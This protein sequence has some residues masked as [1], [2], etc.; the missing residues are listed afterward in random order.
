MEACHDALFSDLFDS[1]K[2]AFL[3]QGSLATLDIKM[4]LRSSP[5]LYSIAYL[6]DA[7][8]HLRIN[9]ISFGQIEN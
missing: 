8:I 3:T 1:V 9:T 6:H 4:D 2:V 7:Y 5:Q